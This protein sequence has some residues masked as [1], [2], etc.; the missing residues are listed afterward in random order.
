MASLTI[1]TTSSIT[2]ATT[3]YT[4]LITTVGL[5]GINYQLKITI[6]IE[7]RASKSSLSCQINA[8]TQD[9]TYDKLTS[10]VQVLVSTVVT[11]TFQLNL[12]NLINP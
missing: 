3:T 2:Y 10:I 6:P 5:A 11:N 1:T 9:C 12:L 7:V 4:L 8:V